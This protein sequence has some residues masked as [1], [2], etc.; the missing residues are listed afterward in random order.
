MSSTLPSLLNPRPERHLNKYVKYGI[1]GLI[2]LLILSATF[3]YFF[4]FHPETTIVDA[5]MQDVIGGKYQDAYR[6]WKAG[7]SYQYT[8]FLQDWGPSGYY[9][10]VRSYSIVGTHE[11]KDASGVIVVV[12]VSPFQPFPP[13]DDFEKSVKTKEV[14]LW[15]QFDGRTISYAP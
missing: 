8:D 11:P 12:D 10:P 2:A 4:R 9:G 6:L 14:R 7:A 13:S 3:W 1:G 5:F 15:V